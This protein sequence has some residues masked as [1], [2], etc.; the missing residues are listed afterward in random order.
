MATGLDK[1]GK[2][3]GGTIDTIGNVV[4]FGHLN[5]SNVGQIIEALE[6]S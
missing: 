6:T 4:T 5:D 3:V 1:I 2:G